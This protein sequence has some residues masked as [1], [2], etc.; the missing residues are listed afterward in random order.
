[1]YISSIVHTCPTIDCYNRQMGRQTEYLTL[2]ELHQDIK[3]DIVFLNEFEDRRYV[4]KRDTHRD[5]H[6]KRTAFQGLNR[7]GEWIELMEISE[8]RYF[9]QSP[10]YTIGVLVPVCEIHARTLLKQYSYGDPRSGWEEGYMRYLT[11][12][13][14]E[15]QEDLYEMNAVVRSIAD[16]PRLVDTEATAHT[17]FQQIETNSFITPPIFRFDPL[18]QS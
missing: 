7:Y 3:E 14:A 9:G 16:L 6:L 2:R 8:E 5:P 1:M 13:L 4:F 18:Y 10:Y 12:T 17:F 11:G 15:T